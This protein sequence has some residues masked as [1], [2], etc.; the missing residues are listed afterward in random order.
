M[1]Q[2]SPSRKLHLGLLIIA[3]FALISCDLMQE[4]K[5]PT[6]TN[7]IEFPLVKESVSL[8]DLENED[9]ISSQLYGDDGER[10][11]FAYTDTTEMDSQAV[12]DQLAFG[13]I[14]QSFSQSVDD[15]TVTGSSIHQTS[16]FEAVGVDPIEKIV[17]SELG[18]IELADIPG[19]TTDPFQLNEMVPTVD[20]IPVGNTELIP[21]GALAPVNKPFSFTDFSQ[22]TFK[23]G[24]L[25][26]TINNNM[27]IPL[28][29]P[30]NIELREVVGT[31]TSTIPG[32]VVSWDVAVGIGESSMRTLDL[33]D[34]TL[35]GDILVRVTGETAGSGVPIE[36]TEG[37]K[38]SSFNID[39][40]G[41][42]L[43]VSSATAK[44]PEQTISESGEIALEASENKI[45]DAQIKTGSLK[46][47]VVNTME[48]ASEL[49]L[50]IT[51]LKDPSEVTFSKTIPIVAEETTLD[52][53]N[54]AGYHLVMDIDQQEV[55]YSY[56]INTIDTDTSLVTLAQEDQI[57]V[58]IALYGEAAG[59]D[60]F[61][62]EIT[63]KIE[64]QLIEEDGDIEV[65]SESKL[66]TADIS[67]GSIAITIDNQ[68]NKLHFDG[69]P[70]LVL[71]IPELLDADSN[72]LTGTKTL[73]PNINIMNFELSD[74]ILVFSDTSAAGQVLTYTTVVTTP[75][76]E[77]GQYGL[78]DSI[79]V[80]IVV[81]D[82][83]FASVTGYFTQDAIVTVDE[84]A[85][86]EGTKLIE[87]VFETGNLALSMTNGIG[88]V[89]DVNFKINEFIRIDNGDTL[90]LALTLQDVTKPQITNIDL[91]EY[92]LSF[93]SLFVDPG[94]DQ[95]IHYKSTVALPPDSLMTLTFGNSIDID[96]DITEL[97]MLSIE[98]II[99]ADTLVIE[100]SEQ[101]IEMPEM[102]ADLMF[103]Q[104]NLEID[105]NSTF[106]VPIA[107]SLTLAGT[108]EDGEY[109]DSTYSLDLTPEND[110]IFIDAAWLL[111]IHPEAIISSGQAV[112]G[113]GTDPSTIAKGQGMYPVMYINVPLS[114]II[115]E[116]P[117]LD[118]DVSS[119]DSPLPEDE[120]VILEEFA[121]FADVTN[122]FEFG[123]TVVV[124]ASNDS[125]VF[126]SLAVLADPTLIPD[127]LM[128]LNIMPLENTDPNMGPDTTIVRM[129]SDK[130]E[131][132][133]EKLWLKPEV[134][135]LG[136]KDGDGNNIPSRFFTSDSLTI[137]TWG[138]IS[139]T[140]VGEEF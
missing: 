119:M 69:L 42:G 109:A 130:L 34:K 72:P 67:S 33:G 40:A 14:T 22:A 140:I 55:L 111:N 35:P 56:L 106:E 26:I 60:I 136:R 9:N 88:V 123:A 101:E 116:P 27:A 79:F 44:V 92:T 39:I 112:V 11:I 115:E 10:T 118:M 90:Q 54:I 96:V 139:Y 129:T 120:T 105:F 97:A 6:W 98:G 103:E 133:E 50:T 128:T 110:R 87:A 76:G 134:T 28:G 5:P 21:D 83:E 124:L 114:L 52:V 94:V 77:L 49:V 17:N 74:Y 73:E 31:D 23:S 107:L 16:A 62:D 137:R 2:K 7:R 13:D 47:E 38:T 89:A 102:V 71:T 63:G 29:S 15:V 131:L 80:D 108:N 53:T 30:I 24:S 58:T 20:D 46:I 4:P 122:M 57:S 125:L 93:D 19:T 82:M 121:L 86:E 99:E 78:E 81:D 104:V 126:D 3:I 66:L 132:L 12:G 32:C 51:S 135:L 1:I 85:L 43:V 95:S 127:T 84:I 45:Q 75:S 117:A 36:I 59:E 70:T 68:I 48:V 61:F 25:N 18:P 65:S 37:V 91:S 64:A 113:G 138:S 100:E 41:S 8:E